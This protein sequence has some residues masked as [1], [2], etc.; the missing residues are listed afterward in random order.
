MGVWASAGSA[1]RRRRATAVRGVARRTARRRAARPTA[2]PA[3]PGRRRPPRPLPPRSQG[4]RRRSSR[5]R[6]CPPFY[7]R[8]RSRRR[9]ASGASVPRRA[10]T[11]EG[12][13]RE[14]GE[15]VDRGSGRLTCGEQ[16]IAGADRALLGFR[17]AAVRHQDAEDTRHNLSGEQREPWVRVP[18]PSSSP[19]TM[20]PAPFHPG[21]R[22]TPGLTVPPSSRTAP[23]VHRLEE[24]Q[25]QDVNF[26]RFVQR[27]KETINPDG[28]PE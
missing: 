6:G 13:G 26:L 20:P 24:A 1:G 9:R 16:V 23:R 28:P 17:R 10:C 8:R 25:E 19:P 27:V 7:E 2:R 4:R 18:P 12:E 21:E 3:P 11:W 14:G 22:R 15:G 5:R